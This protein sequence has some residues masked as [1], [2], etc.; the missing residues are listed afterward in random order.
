MEQQSNLG[1]ESSSTALSKFV[2]ATATKANLSTTAPV[3]LSN[4]NSST[5]FADDEPGD[6]SNKR[7]K[8]LA[9][10][11][12]GKKII[13]KRV[14]SR[15]SSRPSSRAST[16]SSKTYGNTTNKNAPSSKKKHTDKKE[17]KPAARKTKQDPYLSP[18][19]IKLPP[20]KTSD[21]TSFPRLP[22][23]L[24]PS[25]TL[26]HPADSSKR[27]KL[28]QTEEHPFNRRGFR[29]IPCEAN[30]EM[31]SIMYRQ[32][33]L[34]PYG[35]R[36]SYEDL[37]PQ[38]FVDNSTA[39]IVSTDKGFRMARANVCAREGSWF[40]E[41]RI[42]RANSTDGGSIRLGWTRREGDNCELCLLSNYADT[43]SFVQHLL[44]L[45]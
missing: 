9:K 45:P 37:S 33:E 8:K 5:S 28:Y 24:A 40:W 31:P 19:R 2:S 11:T 20:H 39:T 43:D 23:F 13:S 44:R 15:D 18:L 3:P 32:I 29:Y 14:L 22:A 1:N 25:A 17:A 36:V 4:G 6:S 12:R 16:P 26:I 41:C 42:I 21:F 34:P 35:P 27:I 7:K 38:A 30:T 10:E